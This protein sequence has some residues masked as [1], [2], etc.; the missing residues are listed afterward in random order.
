MKTFLRIL[1]IGA[2]L[3]ILVFLSIG[4]VRVVPKALSSLASATVSIGSI[5]GGNGTSTSSSY[6]S[7]TNSTSTTGTGGFIII[8]NS[9]SSAA[10]T[11]NTNANTGVNSYGPN[12]YVPHPGGTSTGTTGS[13]GT[14]GTGASSNPAYSYAGTGTTACTAAGAPDIAVTILSRGV[15]NS[16]GQYVETNTFT[17]NDMVAVKF[18]VENRGTCATGVWSLN[19][20]MPAQ[21]SADQVRNLTGNAA[22]PAGAAVT[23]V[24]NF[25]SPRL[26]AS[27][28]TLV[29]TDS[30]GRDTTTANNT[31]SASLSVIAGTNINNGGNGTGGGYISNGV[32][33]NFPVY[34]DG[35]PDLNVRVIQVGTL[36]YNN[37]FTPVS[38]QN[39]RVGTRI[40]V[41]FQV[42]NQGLSQSGPWSFRAEVNDANQPRVYQDPQTENS[43]PAGG[44]SIYTVSFDNLGFGAHTMNL[45]ADNLNQV[46]EYN[47]GN[48]SYG[49]NFYVNY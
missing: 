19:V 9:T 28:I 36:D 3:L 43:I 18:K 17:T 14:T 45:Y 16:A 5:F 22:L 39:F 32:N 31:A 4:I 15:V 7:T 2:I 12:N 42:V 34:G 40:A 30:S 37:N 8:G 29:V 27:T 21:N 23:G 35:R 46:N 49:V 38:S 25:T 33:G 10:T 44:S 20:Q 6:T 48:N 24:A 47:E 26:G 1:I 13:N 41:K 11:T